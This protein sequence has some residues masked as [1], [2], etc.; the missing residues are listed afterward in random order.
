M[1]RPWP[2][3]WDFSMPFRFSSELFSFSDNIPLISQ[4][5][6]AVAMSIERY[7]LVCLPTRADE[8]L[9]KFRRIVFYT[10]VTSLIVLGI[11]SLTAYYASFVI[12]G[13]KQYEEMYYGSSPSR[14]SLWNTEVAAASKQFFIQLYSCVIS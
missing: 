3:Y 6:L 2:L 1:D 4:C 5:V 11:L 12:R 10:I 13:K 7:I 8:L 14:Y 9:S